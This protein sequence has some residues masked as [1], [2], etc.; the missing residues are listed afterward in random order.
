MAVKCIKYFIETSQEIPDEV[1]IK[2]N[3]KTETLKVDRFLT[4]HFRTKDIVPALKKL[5]HNVSKETDEAVLLKLARYRGL[6]DIGINKNEI[7]V[8]KNSNLSAK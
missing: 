5:G 8:I 2:S 7:F 3:G 1:T 4:K 6:K